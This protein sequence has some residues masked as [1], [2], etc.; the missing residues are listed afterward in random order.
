MW[1]LGWW[2]CAVAKL[3]WMVARV[4]LC[5]LFSSL[6]LSYASFLWSFSCCSLII[7]HEIFSAMYFVTYTYS[8][9][10]FNS[11]RVFIEI[12]QLCICIQ[13]AILVSICRS[14]FSKQSLTGSLCLSRWWTSRSTWEVLIVLQRDAWL[15]SR[16]A[17]IVQYL[18]RRLLDPNSGFSPHSYC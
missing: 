16:S 3:F 12:Q 15:W 18:I 2:C 7:N 10:N 8:T 9:F 1:F 11:T 6:L 13:Y 4:L 14:E 17:I 5:R